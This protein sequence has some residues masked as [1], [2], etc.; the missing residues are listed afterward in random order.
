M[1]WTLIIGGVCICAY[2]LTPVIFRAMKKKDFDDLYL[3]MQNARIA[4]GAYHD[5]QRRF[6]S[7]S[8]KLMKGER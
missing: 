4:G 7:Y 5:E 6:N 2:L 1:K 8:D 3:G